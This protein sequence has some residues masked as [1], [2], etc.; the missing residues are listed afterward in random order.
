MRYTRKT[1]ATSFAIFLLLLLLSCS[2]FLFAQTKTDTQENGLDA[3]FFAPSREGEK[4]SKLKPQRSYRVKSIY[5]DRYTKKL[6]SVKSE[7]LSWHEAQLI[8]GNSMDETEGYEP[9]LV[10]GLM[11]SDGT[12]RFTILQR[13]DDI[14]VSHAGLGKFSSWKKQPLVVI[15]P[16]QPKEVYTVA[17]TDL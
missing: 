3:W 16:H 13:G 17:Q 5:M 9:Y 1:Q 11:I 6:E 12:G 2:S 10:R 8:I 15:L 14:L 4:W 7:K